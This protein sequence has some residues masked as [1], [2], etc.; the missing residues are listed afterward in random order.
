MAES[1]GAG[2]LP[3]RDGG[4]L[5]P[6]GT[7]A[8]RQ[9]RAPAVAGEPLCIHAE[10]RVRVALDR[11][12]E[13]SDRHAFRRRGRH[14]DLR[15]VPRDPGDQP[16]PGRTAPPRSARSTK[17]IEANAN[18]YASLY[19]GVLQRDWFDAQARG[20]RSTLDM[21][22]HGNNIPTAVV[23]N[24]I[25]RRPKQGAEPLRRYH[26]LRKRVLGLFVVSHLRHDDPA[27][28][29]RSEVSVRGRARLA[30]ALGGAARRRLSAAASRRRSPAN[31]STSTRTPASAAAPTP[32]RSTACHPYMLLNYNDTLDAVF[33]LAH[34][35]G[36][37]MHTAALARAPAVR[38]RRLHDLR[39]GSAVD[40]ERS[41]VPRLHA[42]RGP[43]ISA[44]GS[45][46]CSTPSTASSARSTRR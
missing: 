5:S 25:R 19:N 23:E 22:L 29:F 8:R 21:A 2:R 4:S 12:R 35:M 6:A 16:E 24:L 13:V 44:S 3:V 36:H 46:C 30:A 1:R 26:R 42:R 32:R 43:P 9:R 17:L 20:Y 28:R 40:A 45:C 38:L 37:S 41:A 10:R 39:R 27:G 18:T 31:G 15:P 14:A 34:E 11:R 33:T 7:R